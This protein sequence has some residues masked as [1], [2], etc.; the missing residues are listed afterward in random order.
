MINKGDQKVVER[1]L[2]VTEQQQKITTIN[3]E[4]HNRVNSRENR[5]QGGKRSLGSHWGT[6]GEV[7]VLEIAW[8][9]VRWREVDK[10]GVDFRARANLVLN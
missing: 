5:V 10:I 7:A 4:F 9:Q 2:R 6:P 1:H 8:W 3:Q